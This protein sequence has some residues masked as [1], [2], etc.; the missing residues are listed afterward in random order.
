MSL[1]GLKAIP[2]I[3]I[4]PAAALNSLELKTCWYRMVERPQG[5]MLK[6]NPLLLLP[7]I[8]VSAPGLTIV[9]AEATTQK[10]PAAANISNRRRIPGLRVRVPRAPETARLDQAAVVMVAS[11]R[12]WRVGPIGSVFIRLSE[13]ALQSPQVTGL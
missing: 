13:A 4:G 2:V 1:S 10:D 12:S 11:Q 6:G 8:E 3:N 5:P 9:L 7:S